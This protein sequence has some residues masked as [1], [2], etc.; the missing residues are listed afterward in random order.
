M[1]YDPDL[2]LIYVGTGNAEPWV[3]KFRGATG[4]DNLYSCSILAVDVNTGKLKWHYQVTP[5]D[6]WDYDAVAQLMLVDLNI[7]GRTRKV[8]MQ[9]PKNGFFYVLDRATGELLSA[10]PFVQVSWAKGIDMKTGR[11]IMTPE[12]FYDKTPVT[13]VP[14]AGGAHNWAPM[15][16]NPATGLVYIPSTYGSWTFVAGDQVLPLPTGHTGLGTVTGT[17]IV[18]PAIGP[19]PLEGQRG[20]L[21][22]WDPV[23]QK[24]VW[25]VPGGGGIGG[26]TLTTAGNLVFQVI[27]DGR[28][29]VYTADKGEKLLE[30]QTNRTGMTP[31]ITYLVDGKQYVAFMGGAGRPPQVVGPTDA[32]V[33]NPPML[34]VFEVGGTAALPPPAV[35]AAPPPAAPKPAPEAPHN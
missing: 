24:L 11:P 3:Q 29:M 18:P 14:T 19:Q 28:F 34:F 12:A 2:N 7:K 30:I 33:D 32:K 13:L 9:A 20:V 1:A 21:Q 15:S 10:E 6:N 22:A 16:F 27:I 35:A 23:N 5:N 8:V 26:G 31:P 25:R 17:P 4:K